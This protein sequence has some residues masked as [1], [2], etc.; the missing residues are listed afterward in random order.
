MQSNR[1]EKTDVMTVVLH[2]ALFITL[3]FSLATGLRISADNPDAVW[4]SA[5]S[6]VLLQGDVMRWHVWA[7]FGLAV[8]TLA[9]VIFLIRAH[10][11]AR[12]ALDGARLRSLTT[13]DRNTRWKV[14][15]VAIYWLAFVLLAVATVTGILLYFFPGL[16][17]HLTVIAV[18]RFVAWALIAYIVVHVVAQL[19][20][21]GLRQLLKI[22]NPKVAYGAA[23]LTAVAIAGAAGASLYVL[24]KAVQQELLV[25]QTASV[26]ALDGRADDAVWQQ[27]PAVEI[28]TNRGVNNPGGEVT[29]TVRM[30]H[31]GEH[32][33]ALFEWP[34]T[35][36]SQKHLP[37]I[38]TEQGWKV[39]Q[40]EY[41]IQDEDDYY[42][43][44]FGVMFADRPQLAGAGTTHLGPHPLPGKPGPAGGR[45]LHY[46]TD[47]SI[48]D[49][50]HWKSVRTG[51]TEQIDDNY[52]GPPM[53]PNPKKKRYTGGYTQDP[54]DGG[55]YAMNWEEFSDGVVQP[56]RL[57][58][59]PSVLEQLGEVDLD[60][61]V[62][63]DGKFW[64]HMDE[65]VE[66]SPELDA[67]PVGTVM[68]SVL[69]KGPRQGDRGEVTAVGRWQDGRWRLEVKRKL[70]TGSEYDM[71]FDPEQP[72]FLWVAVFDHTQTRHSQHLHPVRVSVE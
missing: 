29:V 17:A 32:L 47:D 67:Y 34:D 21:G 59:D 45:G 24:D 15:N 53:E 42:E 10:L 26:P 68:P 57:P 33:Y 20:L 48:V 44:K 14:F 13:T 39:Q 23:A 58:K 36:R 35:T 43:D 64:M 49:V 31:D 3:L 4:A 41:G 60:P 65:T 25:V 18:H 72:L 50:W 63:D 40:K 61:N 52:F 51:S 7:A 37:L 12:V 38:K 11:Q 27:A 70:D 55:G 6:A 2:W 56:K 19:A 54:S 69:V 16:L 5:L 66:Y 9:Y 62:S 22:F 8:I 1:V 71:A 28:P 46:T 30:A